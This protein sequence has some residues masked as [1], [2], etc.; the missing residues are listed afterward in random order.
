MTVVWFVVWL[1]A[2]AVGQHAALTFDPVNVWA[3]TLILAL[4]LDI[5]RPQIAPRR[6]RGDWPKA[7]S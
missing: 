4:A 3:A 6:A 7:Q 5:N 2:N 1:I